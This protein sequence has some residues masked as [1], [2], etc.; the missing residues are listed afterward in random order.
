MWLDSIES[1]VQLILRTYCEYH[2]VCTAC[3]AVLEARFLAWV[4]SLVSDGSL[5]SSEAW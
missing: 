1:E 3:V 2:C 5:L 4:G